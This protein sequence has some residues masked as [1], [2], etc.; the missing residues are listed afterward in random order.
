MLHRLSRALAFFA[1][2]LA[3]TACGAGTKEP[4]QAPAAS[5]GPAGAG[6]FPITVDAANGA[7]A[8][9]RRPVRIVS[10]SPT[11]TETL[12]A[13]G[14]GGQVIA[15]DDQSNYPKGAP[16]TKLSGYQPNIEAIAGYRPDLVVAGFDPGGLVRGLEKV[17]I[18]V[19]LQP[20]ARNLA[21]AY[22]QVGQLA[23]ATG[24]RA[25]ALKLVTV[26][27]ARI[28]QL[29]ASVPHR[30]FTVFHELGPDLY[31]ATSKTFIGSIYKLLGLRNI[32]DNA[33]DKVQ[34]YP[35]LSA[36][37][38]VSAN[39]D[40]IVLSDTKCCGQTPQ[41]VAKRPGWNRI[42]AV[43]KG[44]VLAV[45][46]DIASRWG[47]RTVDFVQQVVAALKRIAGT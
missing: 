36:E 7:V 24:R 9:M 13:I 26:M 33:G 43:R 1:C 22:A 40:L 27:R 10:L 45:D 12:F 11:A 14:A 23:E 42:D 8:L 31:S 37:Y 39:P 44:D 18:P 29:V 5:T 32:A 21:D 47:P 20:A 17:H 3:L 2:A 46:D 15:V 16:H 41:T 6:S 35:N 19:L 34:D 25:G 38:V 28:A 30:H 4:A